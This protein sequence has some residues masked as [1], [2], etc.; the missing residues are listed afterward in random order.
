MIDELISFT[1]SKVEVAN[2]LVMRGVGLSVDAI[3]MSNDDIELT[4]L[5]LLKNST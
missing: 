2:Q 4:V 3:E 1:E 5:E